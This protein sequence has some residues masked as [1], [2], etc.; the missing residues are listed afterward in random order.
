MAVVNNYYE[1]FAV[2]NYD[3]MTG[4][5]LAIVAATATLVENQSNN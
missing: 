5:L 2:D 1:N 4:G 3:D